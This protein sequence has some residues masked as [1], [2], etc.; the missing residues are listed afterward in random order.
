MFRRITVETLPGTRL[1]GSGRVL[2]D[3]SLVSVSFW[4]VSG[5][6]FIYIFDTVFV[7]LELIGRFVIDFSIIVDCF[8][9]RFRVVISIIVSALFYSFSQ[10]L[11]LVRWV[12][13]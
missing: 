2:D 10:E 5:I 12:V 3:F 1:V 9:Y 8:G 4:V 11:E 6:Y 7:A 13:I